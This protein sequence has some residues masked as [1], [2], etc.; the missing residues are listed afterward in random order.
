MAS[1]GFDFAKLPQYYQDKLLIADVNEL[2]EMAI[3][4]NDNGYIK[5]IG[6]N[7]D[8]GI[9]EVLTGA[10]V[11]DFVSIIDALKNGYKLQDR[12]INNMLVRGTVIFTRRGFK[13]FRGNAN[14]LTQYGVGLNFM[15]YRVIVESN[16][17]SDVVLEAFADFNSFSHGFADFS[18]NLVRC[19]VIKIVGGNSDNF[20]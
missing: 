1:I 2:K 12:E 18:V 13:N 7:N 8:R 9:C 10:N 20:S 16:S 11:R 3:Y 6:V 19:A 14:L 4:L 17:V 5:K 15:I